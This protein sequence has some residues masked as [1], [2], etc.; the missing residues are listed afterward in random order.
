MRERYP[1]PKTSSL[2][3]QLLLARPGLP[4]VN[5]QRTVILLSAHDEEGAMGVVLNRPLEKKLGEVNAEFALGPL[6]DLPLYCG[7]PVQ[8]EQLVI[9]LWQWVEQ[10][11]AFQ[12][13]FGL[14][15]AKAAELVGAPGITLRA[16]L[17]YSGWGKGQLDNEMKHDTWIAT[18]V[19]GGLL[20]RIDGITLWRR[21][22]GAINPELR[23]LANEP[24]D[25]T[26]N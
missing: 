8:P 24:D 19:E 20:D 9:V 4:D 11:S 7:G 12:L 3:G 2:A 21:M 14:E 25:P 26:V 17:G 16:F 6:A 22:L 13:H 1:T 23:L 15:P 10:E 18:P 5:F